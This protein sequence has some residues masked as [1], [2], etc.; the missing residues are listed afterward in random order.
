VRARSLGH[1][2]QSDVL[3]L[4]SYL[5]DSGRATRIAVWGRSMGAVTALLYAGR[6]NPLIK[7]VIVDSPFASLDTLC[8]ELVGRAIK[9]KDSEKGG[10]MG[11]VSEQA[12]SMVNSSMQYR[13]KFSID[14]VNPIEFMHTCHVPTFFING[15]ND[16]VIH[17]HHSDD[18]YAAHGGPKQRKV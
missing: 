1:F 13:A 12:I 18:L 17:P 8:H 6:L 3:E 15:D 9:V 11:F 4:T 10:F 7:C 2:E 5:K 16:K 14:D